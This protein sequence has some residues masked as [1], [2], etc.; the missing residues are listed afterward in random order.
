M[1]DPANTRPPAAATWGSALAM[2]LAVAVLAR[3]PLV[4]AGAAS[5]PRTSLG[6]GL[7]RG[8]APGQER[9][10]A[11]EGRHGEAADTP[12][13]FTAR[14][15]K[16]ILWRVYGEL[17]N[18]RVLAVAAGV[19]FYALLALFPAIT[20]LVSLY[21][22]LADPVTISDQ[23]ASLANLMPSGA[24]DIIGEQVKRIASKPHGSLG[25]GFVAGLGVALWS[26]NA[27]VK[28]MFDAL[29]IV[30]D[31]KEK[32]SFIR[33]NAVSLLCTLGGLAIVILALGAVVVIPVVL[34]LVGLG[35]VLETTISLARWPLLLCLI[36]LALA[37]LYRVGPSRR[38]PQWRWVTWGSGLAAVAWVVASMLFSWYVAKFGTYNE[39]YG[40]LGAAIGF[41]TWIW[42]STTVVLIGA[43]VNAEMEHQ[44][45]QDTTEGGGKPMGRRGA[46]MA[47]KVAG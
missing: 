38:A 7:P 36:M 20:A 30:Y 5:T 39:T 44:T 27:G 16:D 10:Q 35:S 37:V 40:S 9:G 15:W 2:G 34:N 29:N 17:S 26:A 8:D 1:P 23:L 28:A 3:R 46:A 41:M 11:A 21:G 13:A 47:D 22:L 33:L 6:A 24:L 12:A 19:T 43:E 4:P 31:E 14:S 42:I 25:F 18:D 45:P 32:R